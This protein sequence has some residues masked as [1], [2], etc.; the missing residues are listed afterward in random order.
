MYRE[1]V[2]NNKFVFNDLFSQNKCNKVE[3]VTAFTGLLEMSRRSK[4]QTF[5]NEL[6]GEILVEKNKHNLD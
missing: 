3:V 4:V 2:K 5:Q 6:F 1:L